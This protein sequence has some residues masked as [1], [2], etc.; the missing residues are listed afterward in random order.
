MSL[1]LRNPP[2]SWA[3]WIILFYYQHSTI[4]IQPALLLRYHQ[5][6]NSM[7]CAFCGREIKGKDYIHVS[8]PGKT[9]IYVHSVPC[10]WYE[11]KGDTD[12]GA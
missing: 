10:E 4:P 8:N 5:I 3:G 7:K 6:R 9:D 11:N 2:I 1:L 12:N